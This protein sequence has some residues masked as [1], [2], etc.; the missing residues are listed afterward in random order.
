MVET[1]PQLNYGKVTGR[2]LAAVGD[3]TGDDD[4]YPDDVP[5]TGTVTFKPSVGA[6]LLP[7]AT[8]DPTIV[9][10][11]PIVAVLDDNGYVS[12]NGIRGIFLLATDTTNPVDW[13]WNV[14]FALR[15]GTQSV[16][17]YPAFDMS[18]PAGTVKDLVAVV[19]FPSSSGQPIVRDET[20]AIN[21]EQGA[22]AAAA[23]A[24]H[25]ALLAQQAAG[26]TGGGDGFTMDQINQ[27][28][29]IPH[30]NDDTPHPAYDDM[31]SL[32][33]FFENGLS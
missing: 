32:V 17:P 8:P 30:I 3:S 18:L 20:V 24:Q 13:T 19:P 31:A 33:T 21:A 2:F 28:L 9:L 27:A 11:T 1:L 12:L 10:P 6:I 16:I 15:I 23:D 7:N 22:L 29:V 4:L 25:W 26:E 14:S 5:M